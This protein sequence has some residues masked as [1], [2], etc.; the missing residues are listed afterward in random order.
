M[1]NTAMENPFPNDLPNVDR[2]RDDVVIFLRHIQMPAQPSDHFIEDEEGT[3]LVQDS[4]LKNPR[5]Q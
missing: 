4:F 2:S 1:R 5:L 3:T